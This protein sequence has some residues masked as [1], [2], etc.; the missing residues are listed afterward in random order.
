MY[1]EAEL[2]G[3]Y[4]IGYLW[5]YWSFQWGNLLNLYS[6]SYHCELYIQKI[7]DFQRSYSTCTFKQCWY[8]RNFTQKRWI[9]MCDQGLLCI[10]SWWYWDSPRFFNTAELR[11][12]YTSIF[13]RQYLDVLRYPII[14][15]IWKTF[16]ENIK[17]HCSYHC[18]FH[19]TLVSFC[20]VLS[21]I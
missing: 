18:N 4:C 17:R 2:S 21:S 3:A 7:S 9:E 20:I 19:G 5:A 14:F 10:P 6:F 12:R 16:F 11:V 15:V 8:L 1:F 13:R